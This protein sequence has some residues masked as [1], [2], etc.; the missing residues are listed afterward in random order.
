M[1]NKGF[2]K[3]G[4]DLDGV[5][6]QNPLRNFRIVAKK[7]KVIKPFIFKQKVEPFY[8]PNSRLEKLLWQFLH[9]SSFRPDPAL[10]DIEKLVNRNK[11]KAYIITGRFRFLKNDFNYWIKKLNK[12]KIFTDCL[13]NNNNTQP[14]KF[15]SEMINKLKLDFFVEDNYDII[16]RLNHHT[17]AKILWLSN[18]LDQGISYPYK[19]FSLKEILKFLKKQ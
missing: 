8:V 13:I 7:L 15:K 18:F 12:N 5:I 10:S 4:F 14:D 19:F 11:I 6:L 17:K 16:E 3:V 2:L 9:W 1:K